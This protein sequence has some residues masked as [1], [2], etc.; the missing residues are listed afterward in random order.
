[1]LLGGA[2]RRPF[3]PD[4]EHAGRLGHFWWNRSDDRRRQL[5][6]LRILLPMLAGH[7]KDW[8]GC[9]SDCSDDHPRHPHLHHDRSSRKCGL[10]EAGGHS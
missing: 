9:G 1:M 4:P 5:S 8:L 10:Q 3:E 2:K 6:G 7:G